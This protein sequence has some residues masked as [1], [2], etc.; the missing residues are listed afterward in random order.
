MNTVYRK[1]RMGKLP[2]LMIVYMLLW[3]TSP[4]LGYA[5]AYRIVGLLSV[6]LL[7]LTIRGN[8]VWKIILLMAVILLATV[9]TGDSI[10]NRINILIFLCFVLCGMVFDAY[11]VSSEAAER[12]VILLFLNCIVW[13]IYTLRALL[14]L[15]NIMRLSV[16]ASYVPPFGVG[17]YGFLY[18]VVLFVPLSLEYMLDRNRKLIF[19]G[20]AAVFTLLTIF[21]AYKSQYFMAILIVL[22]EIMLYFVLGIKDRNLRLLTTV[23]V[24]VGTFTIYLNAENIIYFFLNQL[25]PGALYRKLLGI[26]DMLQGES[27]LEDGEFATRYERYARDLGLVLRSPFW[28]SLSYMAVGKHSNILDVF[29]QYGLPV[30][31]LYTATLSRRI[32]YCKIPVTKVVLIA[33]VLLFLLNS[34]TYQMGAIYLLLPLYAAI[35]NSEKENGDYE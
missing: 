16:R 17:G 34:Q 25:N 22:L 11:T 32:T 2:L 18:T 3:A 9:F 12:I 27:A 14:V 24:L 21:L 35:H 6:G 1:P 19:R 28:G 26:L 20:I 15:P 8:D 30:G 5:M 13:E 10:N 23:V 7:F 4:P 33:V 31:F 29:A